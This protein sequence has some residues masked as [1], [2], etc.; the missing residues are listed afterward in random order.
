MQVTEGEGLPGQKALDDAFAAFMDILGT[1]T[2]APEPPAGSGGSSDPWE[3]LGGEVAATQAVS[4]HKLQT[5]VDELKDMDNPV[6]QEA[7]E[8]IQDRLDNPAAS[9]VE[10]AEDAEAIA[11]FVGWASEGDETD[12]A[13]KAELEAVVDALHNAATVPNLDDVIDAVAAGKF[14]ELLGVP[15]EAEADTP[16]ATEPPPGWKQAG[17]THINGDLAWAAEFNSSG[18]NDADGEPP[19]R[20]CSPMPDFLKVPV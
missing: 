11:D 16:Q 5:A 1:E 3:T 8:Y 15:A 10:P 18:T 19:K 9:E 4:G 17:A 13:Q 20:T 12:Q 2:E 14:D 6:A 7:A